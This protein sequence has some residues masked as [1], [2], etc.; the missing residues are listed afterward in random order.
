MVSDFG[1]LICILLYKQWTYGQ[2]SAFN[3]ITYI[4]KDLEDEGSE[5]DD[6]DEDDDNDV[7][8]NPNN[9]NYET[10]V[11]DLLNE[12]SDNNILLQLEDVLSGNLLCF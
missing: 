12:T 9:L 3:A 4:T 6:L 1:L 2:W 5:M 11:Y 10:F 7:G 8:H